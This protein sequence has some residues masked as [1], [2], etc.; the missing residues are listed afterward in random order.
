MKFKHAQ[1]WG[2]DIMVGLSLF[3]IGIMIFFTYTL[4]YS[5]ETSE[6]FDLLFYDGKILANNLMSEGYPQ[7]WNSSTAIILGLTTDNRINETKLT[8][9]YDMIYTE[10]NYT[11]TKGLSN[12]IYDYY[13]FFDDNMTIYGNPVEGIGKPGVTKNN[14]NSKNLVKI[15][16]F[17]IC[18]NKTLPLYLY[19]WEE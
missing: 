6:T 17:T 18:Q 15:T 10:N 11:K 3:L 7:D 16:R 13:F 1:I 12:T 5:E 4:N 14:I 9:L 8:N 2:L 19:I